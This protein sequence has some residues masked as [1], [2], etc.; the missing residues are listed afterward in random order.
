[1]LILL[2]DHYR[3]VLRTSRQ[4]NRIFNQQ[5]TR[6]SRFY[7]REILG[8][9]RSQSSRILFGSWL[10]PPGRTKQKSGL[11]ECRC[12][13]CEYFHSKTIERSVG[14]GKNYEIIPGRPFSIPPNWGRKKRNV[15]QKYEKR[16]KNRCITCS[17]GCKLLARWTIPFTRIICARTMKRVCIGCWRGMYG[18]VDARYKRRG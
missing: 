13:S 11:I 12:S 1:M 6:V 7:K 16:G 2:L 18:C 4:N 14:G 5:R 3:H 8:R 17:L 10:S 15:S 9:T